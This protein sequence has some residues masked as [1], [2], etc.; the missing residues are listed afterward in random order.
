MTSH[1]K[2]TKDRLEAIPAPDL[3]RVM[4][5]DTELRGLKLRVSNTGVKTFLVYRKVRGATKPVRVTLGRFPEMTI[6]QARKLAGGYVAQM[7]EGLDPNKARRAE[8][9]RSVTLGDC[10]AAYLEV[11]GKNLAEMSG[12]NYLGRSATTMMAG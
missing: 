8:V 2:F 3:G 11:R 5:H 6:F 4:Y 7:L 9:A 12:V 10:L 1:F